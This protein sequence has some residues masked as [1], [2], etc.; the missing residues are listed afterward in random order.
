VSSPPPHTVGRRL[1]PFIG[2][3]V[4]GLVLGVVPAGGTEWGMIGAS[5]A[6]T[7]GVVLLAVAA[8]WQRLP[9]WTRALPAFVY[10]GAVAVMREAAGG[11][12]AGFGPLLLL[13]V[14][15]L[16]LY[17]T[18]RQ[19][20]AMLVGVA[21]VFYVPLLTIGGPQY[22]L[23]SWRMGA[24]FV[25]VATIVGFTVQN[26]VARLREVLAERADLLVRL[27]QLAASDPLTGLANRRRW[28]EELDRA[29][30]QALRHGRAVSIAAI[31]LD[32]FKA[33]NDAHGH[34]Y[35]DRVLHAAAGAWTE[36]IRPGDV[37]ARLG[38]EEFGL[39]LA[40]CPLAGAH[41]VVERVRAA[42]PYGQTCSAG[43]V[44]WDGR[45]SPSALL[46]RADRMLY[47]A[48]EQGRD[49][50]VADRR[51]GFPTNDARPVRVARTA[52]AA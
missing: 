27:E 1:T 30:A 6:L 22:P 47:L 13:P 18:P 44:E 2:A 19:L 5:I 7:L 40:D 3:A 4:L 25:V 41:G 17:G 48:K 43:I 20:G 33:V 24:L 12:T 34:Q 10:L 28:D 14:F 46:A 16:A 15:W 23:A 35:G 38:G 52:D 9:S 49:R 11:A 21:A 50:S 36:Q 51:S 32:R 39:L 37:L 8:P 31:D 26:L 42:T 45:E 29:L